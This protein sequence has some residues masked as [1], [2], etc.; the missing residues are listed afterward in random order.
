MRI[1]KASLWSA[2]PR[3]EGLGEQ[4][5]TFLK[6]GIDRLVISTGLVLLDRQIVA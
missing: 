6:V 1:L 3:G 2:N 5:P 4:S